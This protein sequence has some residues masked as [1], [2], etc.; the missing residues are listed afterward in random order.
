[1]LRIHA[2]GP[3]GG[4]VVGL[5]MILG[6]PAAHAGLYRTNLL[7]NPSF[8][9][10]STA[11]AA[12]Y[13]SGATVQYDLQTDNTTG[14]GVQGWLNSGYDVCGIR[15]DGSGTG[16]SGD[17]Y[18]MGGSFS[19]G[20]G[21]VAAM[22]QDIDLLTWGFTEAELDSHLLVMEAGAYLSSYP[23]DSDA[24]R[25][26]VYFLDQ[27]QAVKAAAYTSGL[28]APD[29]WTLFE[30][31]TVAV[32]SG[33]RFI[34]FEAEFT[35][36]AGNNNDG[37]ID[38]AWVF[39]WPTV[40]PSSP[41]LD[42]NLLADPGFEL[43]TQGW[44]VTAGN[45]RAR[46]AG[47]DGVPAKSGTRLLA[48]GQRS[49]DTDPNRAAACQ[50]IV[51]PHYGLNRTVLSDSRNRFFLRT[52]AWLYSFQD[53]GQAKVTVDVYDVAGGL[54]SHYDSGR[55]RANKRPSPFFHQELLAPGAY[56]VVFTYD[57]VDPSGTNL[58]GYLDDAAVVVSQMPHRPRWYGPVTIGHRGNSIVAP[59]NTLSAE[60]ACRAG[61]AHLGEF[62]VMPCSTGELVIMHDSTVDRT[63]DGTG[64]V[65]SLSLAQLKALDAGS[66]FSSDFIS[67]QVPTF[68]EILLTMLP[69][70]TPLIEAKSGKAAAYVAQLR[71]L[72]IQKD[73]LVQ[74]FSWSLLSQIHALDPAIRLGALG[75]GTLTASSIAQMQAAGASIVAWEQGGVS[76]TTVN[77]IHEAGMQVFV[78]TVNDM[79]AAQRFI[80]LGV[81]GI[82]TDHPG[83][84]T[85]LVDPAIHPCDFDLD[86]D[87]DA[88]DWTL[89]GGC[90]TA[91]GEVPA[92]G[93]CTT[94]DL[95]R[96]GDVDQSDFGVLQ[97]CFVGSGAMADFACLEPHSPP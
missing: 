23:G 40:W 90:V 25:F 17:Y 56:R 63:T 21:Q 32:P 68:E 96:D 13:Q 71:A 10:Y 7:S 91:P 11:A 59:E 93:F 36:A 9:D 97:R 58:D 74:S 12:V 67:E 66:W 83:G 57:A 79:A 5:V 64:S 84:V 47:L 15:T 81:D 75:S 18:G 80:D 14:R 16:H 4:A 94:A 43:G 3:G 37:R 42:R 51:L 28:Q 35:K 88:D 55:V 44:T 72:G 19:S 52:E 24:V 46:P 60:N 70:V 77:M 29:N 61:R 53:V 95:D 65:S 1:M 69:D 22:K 27:G 39:L 49:M 26:T 34:R 89:F 2:R 73:V 33:T 38:D 85:W 41:M 50:E 31:G 6:S 76:D 62:D 30:S 78:W 48:G 87:V 82:I 20:L 54:L 45:P 86:S 92:A 8:E